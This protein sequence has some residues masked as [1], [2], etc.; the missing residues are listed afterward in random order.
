MAP[1][2]TPVI[3]RLMRRVN[4]ATDD[5]CWEWTGGK[6][7]GGYGQ[8]TLPPT[9]NHPRP[10]AVTHRVTYEHYI[11]PIPDGMQLDHLCRNRACCNPAHLE[12][13]TGAENRRRGIGADITRA[14]HAAITHCPQ[15]HEYAGENLYVHPDGRRNCR[16]CTRESRRRYNEKKRGER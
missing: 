5:G 11:G 16:I 3:E 15:G 8:I 14:R 12:P 1:K 9:P 10:R 2:P 4:I 7:G 13:V 6:S